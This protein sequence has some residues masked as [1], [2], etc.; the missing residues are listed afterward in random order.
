MML[1]KNLSLAEVVKSATAIKFGLKNEPN[2]KQLANLVTIAEN[3]FQPLRKHFGVPIM[4]TSGFRGQALNDIIHG[5]PTSQHCK[6][7]ALD[8]DAHYFGKIT[9]A[10]IF[11]YIKD[12]LNY[13]QLIWEFGN[14]EEPAWIHVSYVSEEENRKEALVA[15]KGHN[16][17]TKYKPF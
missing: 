4:V 8:L 14:D 15:Y 16:R 7:Q 1:T 3:V 10:E 6:G 9:N 5:S 13:D 11:H 17:I 12:F 2:E